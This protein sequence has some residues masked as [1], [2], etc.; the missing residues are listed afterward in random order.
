MVLAGRYRVTRVLDGAGEHA[1][2][3][4]A[5]VE[6]GDEKLALKV[7]HRLAGASEARLQRLRLEV[8][9][10]ALLTHP[11]VVEVVELLEEPDKPPVLITAIARGVPLSEHVK[12]EG[13]L[14]EPQA[15][16][17]A[18]Q[19]LS[20][21]QAAHERGMTHGRLTPG[22]VFVSGAEATVLGFGLSDEDVPPSAD[23][24]AVVTCILHA[25]GKGDPS[26][27]VRAVLDG[28]SKLGSA[29][30]MRSALATAAKLE[31]P[32][33]RARALAL[34]D[35]ESDP[36]ASEEDKEEEAEIE[37]EMPAPP[38]AAS[39][40][41]PL[42]PKPP[43]PPSI[44]PSEPKPV[45]GPQAPYPPSASAPPPALASAP[46]IAPIKPEPAPAPEPEPPA[47]VSLPPPLPEL[48]SVLVSSEPE[49]ERKP[50]PEPA[51]APAF[52]PLSWP[53][54]SSPSPP[55][56]GTEPASSSPA[57]P[58]V[59]SSPAAPSAPA[60]PP[61]P[62][63]S[64]AAPPVAPSA[65]AAAPSP[66]SAPALPPL[67]SPSPS[68]AIPPTAPSPP[69]A[70]SSPMRVPIAPSTFTPSTA[71]AEPP[72]PPPPSSSPHPPVSAIPITA[73]SPP[74]AAPPTMPAEEDRSA[75]IPIPLPPPRRT[76][77]SVPDLAD[78]EAEIPIPPPPPRSSAR[79]LAAAQAPATPPPHT[80]PLP[81]APPAA[82][83]PDPS[84]TAPSLRKRAATAPSERAIPLD[85]AIKTQADKTRED[86]AQARAKRAAKKKTSFVLYLVGS[87]VAGA[88]VAGAALE[89]TAKTAPGPTA[90]P[91][92]PDAAS[93]VA[94]DAA[95]ATIA[96]SPQAVDAAAPPSGRRTIT[97]VGISA[98]KGYQDKKAVAAA[99]NSRIADVQACVR[100]GD[101]PANGTMS[102][103]YDVDPL[104]GTL[105]TH[106]DI[107][108]DSFRGTPTAQCI[109]QRL[110]SGVSLGPADANFFQMH[111]AITVILEAR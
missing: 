108:P 77:P 63:S 42:P 65:P 24:R 99:F 97:A 32:S 2:V 51:S 104:S 78:H 9:R 89:L 56:A 36:F 79:L 1:A 18:L 68:S 72:P 98:S 84:S 96:T 93:V 14:P 87:L 94:A 100:E 39:V 23:L 52:T 20:A 111:A 109:D 45:V 7:L 4:E 54:T 21:L 92:T 25:F 13:S 16:G 15:I 62:P 49:P 81:G 76:H 102:I 11:S 41:P 34:V 83:P 88:V 64:P 43:R 82:V 105:L 3:Y 29:E 57:L 66:S 80:Q 31:T 70:F 6:G 91:A 60:A 75:Q 22:R 26:A 110:K 95:L 107:V 38:R 48:A 46:T 67:S 33:I 58:P 5:A 40:P 86:R 8:K 101:L 30:E 106:T 53:A 37:E 55:A 103:G 74:I 73:P 47:P 61:A 35:P 27:P 17:F 85:P 69:P 10:A 44:A 12:R 28:L 90:T 50:E 71:P 19:V 59:A